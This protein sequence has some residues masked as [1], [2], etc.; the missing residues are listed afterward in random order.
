V[1]LRGDC[2]E[3]EVVVTNTGSRAGRQVAQLYIAAPAEGSEQ[4]MEKPRRE[5]KDFAK[6]RLLQPGESQ[7]LTFNVP[8]D[9]LASFDEKQ[10]SWITDRGTYQ[11][12]FG[13]NVEH[14]L[15]S[16]PFLVKKRTVR[17]CPTIL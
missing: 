9:E 13:D 15:C 5:L 10:N 4:V 8:L 11:A 17:H 3:A 12:E 14:I 16:R 7:R 1:R 2:L 6:T